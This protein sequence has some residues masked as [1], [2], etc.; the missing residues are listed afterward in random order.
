MSKKRLLIYGSKPPPGRVG[1]DHEPLPQSPLQSTEKMRELLLATAL[2]ACV[3]LEDVEDMSLVQGEPC[4]AISVHGDEAAVSTVMD[5]WQQHGLC[6][7]D[8]DLEIHELG[9]DPENPK[10]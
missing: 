6:L 9:P 4:I 2:E 1:P 3:A 8:A 7:V 10:E 5:V